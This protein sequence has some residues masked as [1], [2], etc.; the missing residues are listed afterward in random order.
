MVL[1]YTLLR[2]AEEGNYG[3]RFGETLEV[4]VVVKEVWERGLAEGRWCGWRRGFREQGVEGIRGE[5]S[6]GWRGVRIGWGVGLQQG[7]RPTWELV[8]GSMFGAGFGIEGKQE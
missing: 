3:R 2:C 1:F 6:R 5:C 7:M 8:G 4:L